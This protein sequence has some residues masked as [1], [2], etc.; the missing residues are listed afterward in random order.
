M[1]AELYLPTPSLIFSLNCHKPATPNTDQIYRCRCRHPFPAHLYQYLR[2]TTSRCQKACFCCT[3]WWISRG[4]SHMCMLYQLVIST[5]SANALIMLSSYPFR[6]RIGPLMTG[7]SEY[8]V[9]RWC[10]ISARTLV[11]LRRSRLSCVS[12]LKS[13][14]QAGVKPLFI[15]RLGLS[16]WWIIYSLFSSFRWP[17]VL[18]VDIVNFIWIIMNL[19]YLLIL[20][21]VGMDVH[22]FIYCNH[23]Y[24]LP[25]LKV[26]KAD[27]L[28]SQDV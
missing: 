19:Y 17:D 10:G 21:G 7:Y 27:R 23:W 2:F 8:R 4:V 13:L 22:Q 6:H 25:P 15:C 1:C 28:L 12:L 3:G 26:F 20:R 16:G 24:E 9:V 14:F 11:I 18:Q 5:P